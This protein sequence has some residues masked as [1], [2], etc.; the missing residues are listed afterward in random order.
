MAEQKRA[1]Q[2]GLSVPLS[3]GAKVF[4]VLSEDQSCTCFDLTAPDGTSTRFALT[5]EALGAMVSIR[6]ELLVKHAAAGVT[7]LDGETPGQNH[8][9]VDASGFGEG[10]ERG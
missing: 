3:T 4:G 5:D 7:R 10:V 6:T 1:M 2:I 8:Q 9:G